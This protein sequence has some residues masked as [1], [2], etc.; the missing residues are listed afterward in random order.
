MAKD[1]TT[2]PISSDLD[3]AEELD[4]EA[5]ENEEKEAAPDSAETPDTEPENDPEPEPAAQVSTVPSPAPGRAELEEA[6]RT[7]ATNVLNPVEYKQM[8]NVAKDAIASGAVPTVFKNVDQ[9]LMALVAGREMGMKPLE[10]LKSLYIVNGT[11]KIWGAAVPRRLREH[12]WKIEYLEEDDEHCK[13]RISKGDEVIEDEATFSDA[14]KSGY[15]HANGSLKA[16]WKEGTNRKLKLRYGVL[17]IMIQTYVPEVLGSIDGIVEYSQD[18]GAD[19]ASK[20]NKAR[21]EAAVAKRRKPVIDAKGK[22]VEGG[23]DDGEKA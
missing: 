3:R 13:A 10:S 17:L 5:K 19:N 15:T 20:D 4:K 8:K 9:V 21:A 12:G 22:P 2:D 1:A 16:G 18:F 23:D 6:T 11:L 7:Q 14:E